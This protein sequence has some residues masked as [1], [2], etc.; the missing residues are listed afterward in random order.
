[1]VIMQE[2][3]H[4]EGGGMVSPD[5]SMYYHRLEKKKKRLVCIENKTILVQ[6][7]HTKHLSTASVR[8]KGVEGNKPTCKSCL[9]A[10]AHGQA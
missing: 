5:I 7:W 6:L 10:G 4:V 8:R 3:V 2:T 1:M 9:V